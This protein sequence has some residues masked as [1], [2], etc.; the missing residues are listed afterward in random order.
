MNAAVW[1]KREGTHR[2]SKW[3]NDDWKRITY[4]TD[5]EKSPGLDSLIRIKNAPSCLFDNNFSA[6][7]RVI[8]P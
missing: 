8:R 5:N 2:E 4:L 1:D 3:K 6:S 7:A